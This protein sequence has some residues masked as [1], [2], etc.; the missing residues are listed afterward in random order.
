MA[1]N[2]KGFV[3][4]LARTQTGD[5]LFNPYN[6]LLP[7]IDD[8]T[9]P[10]VRQQNLRLYLKSHD[11]LNTKTLWVF[12]NSNQSE[13]R[14]SGIPLVGS[15][16]FKT[17]E[18]VLDTTRRFEKA[19][20]SGS[21]GHSTTISSV[22]WNVAQEL[23]INPLIWPILPFYPHKKEKP[24]STRR[25]TKDEIL[26]HKYFLSKIIEMYKPKNILAI[27]KEAEE[28]LELLGI[29]AK[30]ANHPKRGKEKFKR[31]AKKYC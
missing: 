9:A 4:K 19:T 27:G 30:F 23:D 1:V 17:A 5:T 25:L 6:Q 21:T 10:G 29:K 2:I 26:E 7:G 28:A 13:A 31:L 12:G 11:N 8:K 15:T 3:Q 16:T 22:L 18:D 20:K 24:L 14:R